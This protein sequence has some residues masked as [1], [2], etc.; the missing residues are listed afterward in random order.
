MKA[1]DKELI[2]LLEVAHDRYNRSSFI[3]SDPISIPHTFNSKEDIEISGFLTA[4]ISWGQ[5]ITIIKNAKKLMELMGNR[6]YDFIISD[7]EEQLSDFKDFK[8][9]TFNYNDLEFFFRSFEN[10]YTNHG[11]LEKV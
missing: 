11:G 5:R 9:R 7:F 3:S 1:N 4:I 10:I 6:P 2:D 8:H